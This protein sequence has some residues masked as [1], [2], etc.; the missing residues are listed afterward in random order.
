MPSVTLLRRLFGSATLSAA[1][2]LG[3]CGGGDSGGATGP[4]PDPNPLPS[5]TSGIEGRAI[6]GL[7]CANQLVLFGSG[8]PGSLARQVAIGGMP[9]GAEMLAIDFRGGDLYGVG[10]D[11]RVYTIDTLSGAASP[12]G[13][14][15]TPAASGDHFGLAFSAAEDRLRLSGVESNQSQALDPATGATAAADAEL[16]YAASDEHAD[17]DPGLAAVAYHGTALYGIETNANTLVGVAPATGELTTVADLPFNVY[18]CSGMDIDTDGTAYAA[19]GTDSGSELYAVNLQ[20][21]AATLLGEIP[22]SSVH[23][24]ALRP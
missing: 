19:L 14:G 13:G 21:G 17:T 7:T 22:G 4:G 18:L 11:S 8:N 20:T 23:S 3:A 9:A 24:I 6:F 15:F 5:P 10:S 2:L 1:A 12:V 16:A